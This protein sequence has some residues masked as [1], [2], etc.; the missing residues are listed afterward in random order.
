M[1]QGAWPLVERK[2]TKR[3]SI[4]LMSNEKNDSLPT[5]AK[6]FFLNKEFLEIVGAQRLPLDALSLKFFCFSRNAGNEFPL[7]NAI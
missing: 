7:S 6:L 4:K 3:Y 1:Y 2:Y 5:P